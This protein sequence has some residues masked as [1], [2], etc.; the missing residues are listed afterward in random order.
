MQGLGWHTAI[1][2]G[3]LHIGELSSAKCSYIIHYRALKVDDQ[4]IVALL[5]VSHAVAM[6]ETSRTLILPSTSKNMMLLFGWLMLWGRSRADRHRSAKKVRWNKL[7]TV[8]PA[9][10]KQTPNTV[11]PWTLHYYRTGQCCV[12]LN[13]LLQ[14]LMS[15]Q[16]CRPQSQKDSNRPYGLNIKVI[17]KTFDKTV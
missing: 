16:D 4:P 14:F 17:K 11:W 8:I 2:L 12:S 3:L 10:A 1:K 6:N 5:I 15:Q 9:N 13:L 7:S